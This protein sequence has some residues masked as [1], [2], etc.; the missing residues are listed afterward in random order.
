MGRSNRAGDAP[1]RIVANHRSEM[2]KV[3][4]TESQDSL[5]MLHCRNEKYEGFFDY[6]G[7]PAS[8]WKWRKRSSVKITEGTHEE[9]TKALHA[10]REG[11]Y[12]EAAREQRKNCRQG[13]A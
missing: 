12:S 5:W 8:D 3:E 13:V 1:A 2:K 9:A 7:C 11:R 4:M 6:F 10:G